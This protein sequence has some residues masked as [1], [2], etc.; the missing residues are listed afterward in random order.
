MTTSVRSI[1]TARPPL[2]MNGR[3]RRQRS[4]DVPRP[5]CPRCGAWASRVTLSRAAFRPRRVSTAASVRGVQA[6]LARGGMHRRGALHAEAAAPWAD[7]RGSRTRSRQRCVRRY[8]PGGHA[9]VS[10]T[11][12]YLNATKT[13]LQDSMRRFEDARCNP[14]VKDAVTDHSLAYNEQPAADS[15]LSL[16]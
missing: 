14:V 11:S 5:S 10:Q 6:H 15:K 2:A 1:S 7:A 13:G 12:R 9:N 16:S 8:D 3:S 4:T